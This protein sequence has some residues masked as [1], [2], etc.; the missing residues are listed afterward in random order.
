MLKRMEILL[1]KA[2]RK[3]LTMTT[4]VQRGL[5]EIMEYGD[6]AHRAELVNVMRDAA[7]H[8]MHTRDGARIACGCLRHGD[9]KDRKAILKAMKGF[10]A[11]A[12]QDP[13]GSLVLC[14]ALAVVDDTVLLNKA[15]L[16][17]LELELD[18]LAFDAHGSLPFLQVLS[19]LPPDIF[20]RSSSL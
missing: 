20:R 3:G 12:A 8:I 10:V 16:S 19:P 4:L 1:S 9:A 2:A 15:V 5:A 18:A 7:V 14:V 11:R 13:H 17:E 6:E